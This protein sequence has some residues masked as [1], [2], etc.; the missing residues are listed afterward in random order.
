MG[1]AFP[2]QEIFWLEGLD[3]KEKK[4]QLI[5]S[6]KATEPD[7]DI[8]DIKADIIFSQ[9]DISVAYKP[10]LCLLVY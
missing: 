8:K 3:G 1:P 6:L 7:L 2:S 9:C 10:G 4:R 5:A